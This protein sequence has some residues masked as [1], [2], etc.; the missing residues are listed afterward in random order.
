MKGFSSIGTY[1]SFLGGSEKLEKVKSRSSKPY[2][3]AQNATP[4]S[5]LKAVSIAAVLVNWRGS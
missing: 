3:Q 4:A 1:A 5:V 2:G